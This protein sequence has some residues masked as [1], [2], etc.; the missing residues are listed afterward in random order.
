[1]RVMNMKHVF[2]LREGLTPV[3]FKLPTRLVGKPAQEA[4]PLAGVTI[5]EDRLADNFFAAM[6]WDRESGKPSKRMLELMGG[7]DDVAQDLHG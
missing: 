3:D 5:D 1:M 2:N 6:G 7:M 4:G